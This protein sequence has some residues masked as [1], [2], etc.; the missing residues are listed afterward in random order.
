M[1]RGPLARPRTEEKGRNGGL[2]QELVAHFGEWPTGWAG[3]RG[4][5][6]KTGY[7]VRN[8]AGLKRIFLEKGKLCLSEHVERGCPDPIYICSYK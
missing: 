3:N 2:C 7:F 1:E 8:Q 6:P 4:K 5:G